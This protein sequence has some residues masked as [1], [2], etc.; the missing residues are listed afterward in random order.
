[1]QES[2]NVKSR[3]PK[4]RQQREDKPKNGSVGKHLG[5]QRTCLSAS[6]KLVT[7][8]GCSGK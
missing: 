6:T 2:W 3:R 8:T 5:F 4:E 1:M 7:V